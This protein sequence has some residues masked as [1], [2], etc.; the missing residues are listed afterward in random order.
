MVRNEGRM[1]LMVERR[2]GSRVEEE[3]EVAMGQSEGEEE[4]EK[5][6]KKDI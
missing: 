3:R 5:R 2:E 4:R 6:K 1:R